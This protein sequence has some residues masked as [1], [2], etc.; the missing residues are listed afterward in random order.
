MTPGASDPQT[1]FED[2]LRDILDNIE[3][4]ERFTISLG[5]ISRVCVT[6]S[7]TSTSG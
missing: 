5:A 3:K 4:V 2:Y 7:S 1:D 6:N